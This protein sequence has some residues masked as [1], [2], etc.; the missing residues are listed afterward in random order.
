M[1]NAAATIYFTLVSRATADDHDGDNSCYDRCIIDVKESDQATDGPG[2]RS[3]NC[4]IPKKSH[5]GLVME[6]VLGSIGSYYRQ[7][8]YEQVDIPPLQTAGTWHS[9]GRNYECGT[10]IT[11]ANPNA[12][13][14]VNYFD[15][16]VDVSE[17]LAS[18]TYITTTSMNG[19]QGY[20]GHTP[21]VRGC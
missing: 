3:I 2:R 18:A 16:M 20:S 21:E 9:S 12:A 4:G 13:L 10:H 14:G 17:I 8:E 15:L 6:D 19:G 11:N 1:I 5:C 7:P